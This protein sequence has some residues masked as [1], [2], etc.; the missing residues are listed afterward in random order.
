MTIFLINGFQLRITKIQLPLPQIVVINEI[1]IKQ[2]ISPNAILVSSSWDLRT[3]FRPEE[4][5]IY[6]GKRV[7]DSECWL[8]LLEGRIELAYIEEKPP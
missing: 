5:R 1:R 2:L 6:H 8:E 4:K 3:M 7:I